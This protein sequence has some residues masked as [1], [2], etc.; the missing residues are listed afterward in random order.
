MVSPP[1]IVSSFIK[2]PFTLR[3]NYLF[4]FR[5]PCHRYIRDY[6]HLSAHLLCHFYGW[7]RGDLQTVQGVAPEGNPGRGKHSAGDQGASLLCC[8]LRLHGLF[9]GKHLLRTTTIWPHQHCRLSIFYHDFRLDRTIRLADHLRDQY[10]A[11]AA[12]KGCQGLG[13]RSLYFHFRSHT[14]FEKGKEAH[15]TSPRTH[16]PYIFN[17]SYMKLHYLLVKT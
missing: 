7:I 4:P 5:A 13:I 15:D 9:G 12:H 6:G 17:R 8:G 11:Y 14:I 16:L 3:T 1:T 2:E 10:C